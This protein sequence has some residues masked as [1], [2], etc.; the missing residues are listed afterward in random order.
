LIVSIFVN[1]NRW[2]RSGLQA[3]E[4]LPAFSASSLVK[5]GRAKDFPAT[6]YYEF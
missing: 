1:F 3:P 2:M 5:P 6:P 4:Y